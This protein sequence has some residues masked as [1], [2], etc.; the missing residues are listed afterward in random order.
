[1]IYA[2]ATERGVKI[3]SFF[4]SMAWSIAVWAPVLVALTFSVRQRA[5]ILACCSAAGCPVNSH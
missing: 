2:I 4:G 1:M 3:P 5:L